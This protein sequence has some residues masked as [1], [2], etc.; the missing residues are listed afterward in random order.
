M[1]SWA[2]QNWIVE[3]VVPSGD[4]LLITDYEFLQKGAHKKSRLHAERLQASLDKF[5]LQNNPDLSIPELR[6][7]AARHSQ[8]RS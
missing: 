2:T 6:K 3:V 4:W 1:S 8:A 5:E 7:I